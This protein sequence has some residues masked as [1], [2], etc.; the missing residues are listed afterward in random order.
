MKHY[1]TI[2]GP[3]VVVYDDEAEDWLINGAI[4]GNMSESLARTIM[5]GLRRDE[6]TAEDAAALLPNG[7]AEVK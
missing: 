4:E 7:K 3:D 2:E 1:F 6:I 5:W